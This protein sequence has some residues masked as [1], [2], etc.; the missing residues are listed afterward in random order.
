MQAFTIVSTA[1]SRRI[2]TSTFY[3]NTE[4]QI[5]IGCVK[6]DNS[7]TEATRVYSLSIG[8]V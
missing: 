7:Q 6:V 1:T 5:G 4:D 3:G 8:I 2:V